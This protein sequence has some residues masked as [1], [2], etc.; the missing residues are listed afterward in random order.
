MAKVSTG[1][2]QNN[3]AVMRAFFVETK[4]VHQHLD[5]YNDFVE[6]KL[7]KIVDEIGKIEPDI[8]NRTA[9][10][11]VS[12]FYLRLGKIHVESPSIRE[13]DGSKKPIYPSEARIRDLTYSAPLFLEMIPVDVDRK[14]GI[15]EQLDL[16][17]IY[18][19]ELP[20][21][22]KSK[23]CLLSGLSDEQLVAQGEDPEDPGGYF[24][25]NGSERV[26]VTQEDLAPNRVLVE[27]A[28]R[29][30]TST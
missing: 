1:E 18:I 23:V 11:Q 10:R 5:S 14:T 16:V 2:A 21:M 29:S 6:H 20:V 28:R 15:E 27:E 22:L 12:Q 9:Q 3:W 24:I 25:I 30:S 4:L 17:K 26:L 19:G 13:A 7:Q 8:Q